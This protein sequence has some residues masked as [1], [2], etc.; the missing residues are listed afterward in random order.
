MSRRRV[1]ALVLLAI[2]SAMVDFAINLASNIGSS[3]LQ[4]SPGRLALF[5]GHPFTAGALLI[6]AAVIGVFLWRS[7]EAAPEKRDLTKELDEAVELLAVRL[8]DNWSDEAEL[9]LVDRPVSLPN[10][11]VDAESGGREGGTFDDIGEVFDR[12]GRL[13]ILGVRG[14]GKTVLAIR[15]V[16]ARLPDPGGPVGSAT[17]PVLINLSTWDPHS[18][19]YRRWLEQELTAAYPALGRT[20]P[21]SLPF[22]RELLARGRILPVLDGLDEM[23]GELRA[24]ALRALRR[25]L[26][27]PDRLLLTSRPT[28]YSAAVSAAGPIP[29]SR[30]IVLQNLV[31]EELVDYLGRDAW[32]DVFVGDNTAAA[33]AGDVVLRSVL[34]TPLMAFLARKVCEAGRATP[35]ELM[36]VNDAA[37]LRERL[38]QEFLPSVYGKGFVRP[39]RYLRYLAEHLIAS[40]SSHLRWW[41]LADGLAKSQRLR[42]GVFFGVM[43]GLVTTLFESP[44]NFYIAYFDGVALGTV[45]G[46][47][48][49][50]TVGRPSV[51]G[52]QL[53]PLPVR[54]GGSL[55]RASER[56]VQTRYH[57]R[58][59]RRFALKLAAFVGLVSGLVFALP[60]LGSAN[61]WALLEY[62]LVVFQVGLATAAPVFFAA[63]FATWLAQRI[64]TPVGLGRSVDPVSLLKLDRAAAWTEAA[65]YGAVAA[66]LGGLLS[67]PVS[68]MASPSYWMLTDH[69]VELR[70]DTGVVLTA[71]VPAVET[72][73]IVVTLMLF[74]FTAW[75]RFVVVRAYLALSHRL[76]WRLMSFLAD[77]HRRGVLRQAGPVYQFRHLEIRDY[78]GVDATPSKSPGEPV[79]KT[80]P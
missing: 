35:G 25:S 23:A 45:A 65:L 40:K 51:L 10:R 64:E 33:D 52:R 66:I 28:E 56:P 53:S 74:L 30:S 9:R 54:I 80:E 60:V 38:F 31:P 3:N 36:A 63:W 27:P 39:E 37:V 71:T 46:I 57:S 62:P 29:G 32:A 50:L 12:T 8:R 14:S 68:V 34:T 48:A 2:V 61:G 21:G 58:S 4:Q 67:E 18:V 42:L 55:L 20:L 13:V 49:A 77:A 19:P 69:G 24:E 73:L 44:V 17:I 59:T 22:A 11:W 78:L 7:A 70:I 41:R 5:T 26:R 72:I 6:I 47:L 75:G 43:C 79:R 76:P 1:T 15:F 16:L